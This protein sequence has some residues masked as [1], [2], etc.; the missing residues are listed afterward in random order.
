[1]TADEED[2]MDAEVKGRGEGVWGR[3]ASYSYAK[4]KDLR[5]EKNHK[6]Q[7]KGKEL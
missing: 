5:E 3:I 6:R 4:D 2:G 7:R 1:M